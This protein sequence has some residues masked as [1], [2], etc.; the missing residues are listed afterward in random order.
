MLFYGAMFSMSSGQG[1]A[2]SAFT[3][4]ARVFSFI[5]R[6]PVKMSSVMLAKFWSAWLP[7]SIFWTAVLGGSAL[8]LRL[9][10]WQWAALNALV[11]YCLAG[12]CFVMVA[13]SARW[14][15]LSVISTHPRLTGPIA[16][17]GM[18]V[19][20]CWNFLG[21]GLTV[22]LIFCLAAGSSLVNGLLD[23]FNLAAV[24]TYIPILTAAACLTGIV[25]ACIPLGLFWLSGL[26]RLKNWEQN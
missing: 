12:T 9:P 7:T 3:Q 17:V 6:S 21:L 14:A 5:F 25:L 23:S 20:L 1:I 10:F 19:G 24:P 2:L 15:D 22:S 16:W 26:K 4:E 8:F 18:L 11:L 13:I